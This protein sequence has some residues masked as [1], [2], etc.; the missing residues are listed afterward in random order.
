MTPASFCLYHFG[1]CNPSED[2]GTMFGRSIIYAGGVPVGFAAI[3]AQHVNRTYTLLKPIY[4]Q[5]ALNPGHKVKTAYGEFL[6]IEP[7]V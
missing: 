7:K 1:I 3:G 6:L 2:F 4:Q 5:C